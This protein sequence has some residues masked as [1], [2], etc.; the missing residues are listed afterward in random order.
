MSIEN[1][2]KI[3]TKNPDLVLRVTKGHFA[4][5]H[6]HTN[7][8]IDVTA[9]K[10]RLSEAKAVAKG[11]LHYYHHN[12]M[13]DTILCL[14]ETQVIGTCLALEL[15]DDDFTNMNAHGTVYVA[16]PEYSSEGK[17]IFRENTLSMIK[18]K[19]VLILAASVTNGYTAEE[20]IKAV[21]YYEGN[22]VGIASIF[23]TCGECNGYTVHSVFN[24]EDLPDYANYPVGECPMCKEGQKLDAIIN[25]HGYAKL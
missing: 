18:G 8:Y 2:Y 24:P 20:A 6:S 10:S 17:I 14:D 16:S 25:A 9:Q 5:N 4:A 3:R 22:P 19:H 23:A 11:L 15:I 1:S 7:Y 13:I 21:K 12:T